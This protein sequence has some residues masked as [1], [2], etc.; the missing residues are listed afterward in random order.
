MRVKALTSGSWGTAVITG[1]ALVALQASLTTNWSQAWNQGL[2]QTSPDFVLPVVTP[3]S[4]ALLSQTIVANIP[5]IV[6]SGIYVF[7]SGLLTTMLSAQELAGFA[8]T[9]KGLRVSPP[10][11]GQQR[12]SYFL[13]VPYRFALP[14]LA[15]MAALHYFVSQ[16]IYLVRLNEYDILGNRKWP[17]FESVVGYSLQGTLAA[18]ILG[19]AMLALPVVL[20][21][22][23]LPSGI[24]LV[25]HNTIAISIACHPFIDEPTE[26]D[27]MPL[28]YGR[29]VGTDKDGKE[30]SRIGFSAGDVEPLQAGALY[31]DT[32]CL[33]TL[34]FREHGL[35]DKC[36]LDVDSRHLFVKMMK[37]DVKMA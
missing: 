1:A 18:T 34:L 2:G 24:P 22:L 26:P 29:V 31:E 20:G 8:T 21:F 27:Q 16:S 19:A 15:S 11:A 17:N 10:K 25:S 33:S 3:A 28:L 12:S 6:I 32:R 4:T 5:Q 37:G 7:Y 13:Q 36:T 30:R 23:K 9:A 35:D 14:I